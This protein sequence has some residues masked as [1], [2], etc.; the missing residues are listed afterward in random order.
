MRQR[1]FVAVLTVLMAI[2]AGCAG[3]SA[4]SGSG[5]VR[6]AL[7]PASELTGTW[8]GSFGWAGGGG[9]FYL[10]DANCVLQIREDGTFTETVTPAPASNNLAKRWTWSGTVVTR[11]NRVTLRTSQGP[12]VTLIHS[13]NM[14]Y[15]VADD[16]LV[17][18][19]I[20]IKLERD[21]SGT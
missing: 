19:A 16:P 10:D 6:A 15:G 20:T 11:G 9:G 13:G 21:G 8:H 2:V 14:L 3:P 4:G 1:A 12:S 17:E 7:A 18:A 5:P